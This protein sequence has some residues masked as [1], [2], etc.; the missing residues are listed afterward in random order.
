[1]A[2]LPSDLNPKRSTR[3]DG[4]EFFEVALAPGPQ[5]I[6]TTGDN[7]YDT[8]FGREWLLVLDADT[9]ELHL[10]QEDADT[11]G[12]WERVT[13]ALPGVLF[14]SPLPSDA[15]HITLQF[16][17]SAR[18]VVAYETGGIIELT[19][20]DAFEATYKQNVS[21]AGHDPS[22]LMD[23]MLADP[24]GFSDEQKAA[25][26]NG[27]RLLFEWLPDGQ[28]RENAIGDSDVVLFYL[29]EDRTG[30]RARAQRQTYGT[31]HTIHDAASAWILDRAIALFGKYQLLVSD[32]SGAPLDNML[33]SN[34]YIGDVLLVPT[35]SETLDA[36]FEPETVRVQNEIYKTADD[37]DLDAL[38]APEDILVTDTTIV[39]EDGESLDAAF[40]PEDA[41]ADTVIHQESDSEALDASFAP[42]DAI[43][44]EV[45]VKH[46]DDDAVTAAFEPETIRVETQ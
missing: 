14:D 39:V 31:V 7:S 22:L 3:G 8:L 5:T 41:R 44:E 16:D 25:I 15:R 30:V 24:E 12:I 11:D 35:D 10:Y 33:I 34:A 32:S 13:D 21:F 37:E 4:Y 18:V 17:Q 42:E 43:A 45:L 26:D 28:Y 19:R 20:W 2:N 6:A 40:A 1:M 23:A 9:N 27:I 38:F 46:N 36:V 29:T